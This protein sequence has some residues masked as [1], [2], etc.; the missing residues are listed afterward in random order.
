MS[1]TLRFMRKSHTSGEIKL[2]YIIRNTIECHIRDVLWEKCHTS[3]EI[4][5]TYIIW[6]TIE[7]HIQGVLWKMCQ[8]SGDINL[9]FFY[10]PAL[11]PINSFRGYQAIFRARTSHVLQYCT[12]ST[13]VTL[14]T[15]SPMKMEQTGCSE[16]LAFKLQTPGNNSE[17]N[18]RHSKHCK[19]LKSRTWYLYPDSYGDDTIKPRSSLTPSK[20]HPI[21]GVFYLEK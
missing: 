21:K 8:T 5:L 2:T 17:E 20:L 13:A 11:T 19:N 6:N 14:H 12:F 10:L 15:Y 18:T 4:K 16:T 7:C 9:H 1:Y 3:G